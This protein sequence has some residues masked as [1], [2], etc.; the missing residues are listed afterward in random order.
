[1]CGSPRK[2]YLPWVSFELSPWLLAPSLTLRTSNLVLRKDTSFYLLGSIVPVVS[3]APAPARS[4][5]EWVFSRG[6]TSPGKCS[7]HPNWNF[8]RPG[9]KAL[10]NRGIPPRVA[11]DGIIWDHSN[12]KAFLPPLT[13]GSSC[14][15]WRAEM[16]GNFLAATECFED[17]HPY[18][19]HTCPQRT[20]FVTADF[21]R[22]ALL[23]S[24]LPALYFKKLMPCKVF[25]K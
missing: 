24:P 23:L 10:I 22:A 3:V 14:Y 13:A 8:Y 21:I 18:L 5:E 15:P 17:I 11:P 9:Q 12:S 25:Y 6:W 20:L 16:K 7:S 19:G 4:S 1:M 2:P